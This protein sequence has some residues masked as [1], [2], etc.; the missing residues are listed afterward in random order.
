MQFNL[1]KTFDSIPVTDSSSAK[2]IF[3]A[4][5]KVEDKVSNFFNL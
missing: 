2:D 4:I 5:K 1:D 3:N